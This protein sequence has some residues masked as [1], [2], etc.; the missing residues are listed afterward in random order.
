VVAVLDAARTAGF[1]IEVVDEGEYFATRDVRRLGRKVADYDMMVAAF[2]GALRDEG[3]TVSSP[4]QGRPDFERLEA[5]GTV[6][7]AQQLQQLLELTR[8]DFFNGN[9]A[10][11]A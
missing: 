9:V 10:P 5:E 1:E 7:Y 8:G 6:R 2:M 11:G 3:T 4:M